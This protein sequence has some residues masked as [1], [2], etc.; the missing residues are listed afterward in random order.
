MGGNT[1]EWKRFY[2]EQARIANYCRT[3][4]QRKIG[5]LMRWKHWNDCGHRTYL[6]EQLE[7]FVGTE[8]VQCILLEL[9]YIHFERRD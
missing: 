2:R 9:V 1:K 5:Y 8:G 6:T 3:Q 7:G 4:L